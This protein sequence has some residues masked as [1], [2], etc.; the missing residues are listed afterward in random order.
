MF[1]DEFQ[2]GIRQGAQVRHGE[3]SFPDLLDGFMRGDFGKTSCEEKSEPP[4]D[5]EVIGKRDKKFP[6][7]FQYSMKF[8]DGI[9]RILRMLD[10]V[11]TEK[12]IKGVVSVREGTVKITDIEL[13]LGNRKVRGIDITTGDFK[14]HL[15]QPIRHNPC[16]ARN[17]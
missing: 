9:E 11:K 6:S 12:V 17:V 1:Q 8:P 16:S 13:E 10:P 4:F 14:S 7:L 3:V 15:P 2:E 5:I